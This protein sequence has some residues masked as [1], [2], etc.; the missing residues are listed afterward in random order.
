MDFTN[1]SL[2]RRSIFQGLGLVGVTAAVTTE[3]L[4][5]QRAKAEGQDCARAR[6]NGAYVQ[7]GSSITAGLHGPGAYVS[8]YVVGERLNLTPVNAGFDGA[9]ATP[10]GRPGPD[11]FCLERLVDAIHAKDWSRQ[12]ASI[13]SLDPGNSRS[14]STLKAVEFDEVTYLGL[15][16]GVNDFTLN[17]TLE[18]FRRSIERAVARLHANFPKMRIFTIGPAWNPEAD[19]PNKVGLALV[20][21][22]KA[23]AQLSREIGMPYLDIMTRLGISAANVDVFT[24]DGKHPNETGARVRGEITAAFIKE[25]F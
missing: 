3:I 16:Y 14:L 12:D 5:R 11:D 24:F 25:V 20:D 21:Y 17:A 10:S 1:L 22:A 6:P 9:T 19:E 2:S 8:P 23:M 7:M 13:S 15:E 4:S 18:D